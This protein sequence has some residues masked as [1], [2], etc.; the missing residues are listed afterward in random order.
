MR[1]FTIEEV[2]I[3]HSVAHCVDLGHSRLLRVLRTIRLQTPALLL[4]AA[5][6]EPTDR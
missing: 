3:S 1:L 4:K 2:S 6:Q 5:R